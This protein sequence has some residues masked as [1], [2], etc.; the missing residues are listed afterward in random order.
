MRPELYLSAAA[1]ALLL[2]ANG[3]LAETPEIAAAPTDQTDP[4]SYT[5]LT[6]P[7]KA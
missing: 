1:A 7:T 4:V 3:A 6:L 2:S 5:H